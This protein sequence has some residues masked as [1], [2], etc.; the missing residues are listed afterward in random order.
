MIRIIRTA[1]LIYSDFFDDGTG[2]VWKRKG[3]I[4]FL[5]INSMPEN[6]P[7]ELMVEWDEIAETVFKEFFA[8]GR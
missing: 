8:S 4:S 3:P 1:H 7:I 5:P 2:L 6:L